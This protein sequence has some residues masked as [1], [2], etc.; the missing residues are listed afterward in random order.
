M[1]HSVGHDPP[2]ARVEAF[3][4]LRRA[5]L[6]RALSRAGFLIAAPGTPVAIA[7]RTSDDPPS[8]APVELS[9]ASDELLLTIRTTVDAST[10]ASL[11]RVV[12]ELTSGTDA[13]QAR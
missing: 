2:Y 9:V 3:T 7:V 11:G 10:W 8:G 1:P 12:Q 13:H 4:H 5:G 6:R